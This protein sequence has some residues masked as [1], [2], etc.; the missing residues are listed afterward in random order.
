MKGLPNV[1]MLVFGMEQRATIHGYTSLL[2][3]DRGMDTSITELEKLDPP[4]FFGIKGEYC[5]E[6]DALY[7]VFKPKDGASHIRFLSH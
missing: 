2:R 3:H 1:Q 5:G 4:S 6:R 7:V